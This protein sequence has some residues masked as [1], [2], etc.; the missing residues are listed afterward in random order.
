MVSRILSVILMFVLS[1]LLPAGVIQPQHEAAPIH[2]AAAG[3]EALASAAASSA[4]DW[5]QLAYDA[6]R[7]NYTPLQV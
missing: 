7:S 1:G 3:E 6:Q 2:L 5:P 4:Q